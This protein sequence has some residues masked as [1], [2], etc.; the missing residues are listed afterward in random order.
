MDMER[1]LYF[2]AFNG[3]SG[4]MILGALIDMGLPLEF[5]VGELRK[6]KLEPFELRAAPVERE[7]LSGINFQV[8]P[9]VP[10]SAGSGQ[11]V[12]PHHHGQGTVRTTGHFHGSS[13]NFIDIRDLIESSGLDAWVRGKSVQIFERLARAEA[14]VHGSS[15]E[16]V[17]FH[18]VGALDSII[19][20]VGSCIG[21]RFFEVDSFLSSP[22]HLGG[23]TVTFSHGTWP[24]PAPATAELVR[25]MPTRLGSIDAELT[26]PTGA[27][28]ITTLST[29]AESAPLLTLEKW[30]FGAGDRQLSGI[31]N[32]LRLML[33]RASGQVSTDSMRE[34]EKE[35]VL[36]LQANID[37]M[38]SEMLGHFLEL[39]LCQGALDVY[40]TPVQMKKSR[41]GYLL[42]LLCSP[43][44]QG[45]MVD[46][47][48]R[49]T[50]TL[51]V[52]STRH[53]RWT[54]KREISIVE[55]EYGPV[56]V[57]VGR[58]NGETVN[59]SPEFEDL[60][61]IAQRHRI[62]LKKLRQQ[63]VQRMPRWNH[64]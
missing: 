50:T 36:L 32:M 28:I 45:K 58:L 57:K 60:K 26:T 22:L 48:F 25:G 4:D 10:A 14:K 3:A 31:P 29:V 12:P 1:I 9:V 17:H 5:L 41:P 34:R 44:D 20:I 13:R 15:V 2:D 51:G 33:G 37:D 42:S 6:L 30:G 7:G 64:E 35:E 24:V 19:D 54:L 27:A 52:R 21:F 38:D 40:Y 46:L 11:A 59:V 43:G 56:R 8:M 18:E 16:E 63:V 39:A 55:T 62:P 47:I 23:G 53:Q 61:A 49:E